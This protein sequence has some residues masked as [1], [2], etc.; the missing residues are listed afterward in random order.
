M[1]GG[2]TEVDEGGQEPVDEDQPVLRAGA[3]S[4]LPRPGGE[5]GLVPLMPQRTQLCDEFSD[6]VGRQARD[7]SVAGDRCTYRAS[8]RT[9]MIGDRELD[10]SPPTVHEFA[11]ASFALRSWLSVPVLVR[12][13]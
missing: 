11:G 3:H 6:H 9:T 13:R 8:D 2:V 1:R 4:T 12:G 5:P 7:P 10:A